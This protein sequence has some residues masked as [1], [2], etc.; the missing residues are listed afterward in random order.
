MALSDIISSITTDGSTSQ[1]SDLRDDS[2]KTIIH[3]QSISAVDE[4][5]FSGIVDP[6][7]VYRT[8]GN[9]ETVSV[10]LYKMVKKQ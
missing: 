2:G 8:R 1:V 4:S 6:L 7:I 5:Q 3:F 9:I 10:A